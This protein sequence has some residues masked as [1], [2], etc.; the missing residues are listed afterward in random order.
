[1]AHLDEAREEA[2]GF[3][4]GAQQDFGDI[5]DTT[6]RIIPFCLEALAMDGAP[7][8]AELM[9]RL[10]GQGMYI[11][12]A[13]P[14]SVHMMD[15]CVQT[16]TALRAG[17][18]VYLDLLAHGDRDERLAACELLRYGSTQPTCSLPSTVCPTRAAR[19]VRWRKR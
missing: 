3:L 8:K 14:Q 15:L 17:L 4:L 10:S 13:M 19:C 7:G 6:P 12:D 9:Q 2:R 16:Y 5:Y 18:D 1:M 11:A